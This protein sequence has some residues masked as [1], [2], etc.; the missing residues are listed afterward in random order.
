MI[1][2]DYVYQPKIAA[3]LAEYI[4]YITP[5]PGAA[6]VIEQDAKAATGED[7]AYYQGLVDSP[8]IFPKESDFAKLH[9]YRVLTPAE[10]RTWNGIFEPIYQS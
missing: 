4:N 8:L 2:M 10:E 7:R 3:M 6:Q 1:Y 5:V 9:R